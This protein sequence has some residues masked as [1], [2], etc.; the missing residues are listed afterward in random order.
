MAISDGLSAAV[1]SYKV[2]DDATAEEYTNTGVEVVYN[3]A[4]GLD[5]VVNVEDYEYK[6]GTGGGTADSGTASKLTLIASF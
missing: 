3:I 5:A 6:A 1:F 2:E 4:S